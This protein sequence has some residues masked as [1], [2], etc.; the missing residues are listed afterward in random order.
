VAGITRE[1]GFE[2]AEGSI[3]VPIDDAYRAKYKSSPY[4]QP[5]IGSRAV[6]ALSGLEA[7]AKQR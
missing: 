7:P 1:V 2:P 4:L 3:N 5:M 6:L